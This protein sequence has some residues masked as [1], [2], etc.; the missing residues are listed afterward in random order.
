ML[1]RHFK[2]SDPPWWGLNLSKL[3]NGGLGLSCMLLNGQSSISCQS[4]S[5]QYLAPRLPPEPS[6]NTALNERSVTRPT[7]TAF[8]P[9]LPPTSPKSK[10]S[11]G[12]TDAKTELRRQV[13]GPEEAAFAGLEPSKTASTD[14]GTLS[15]NAPIEYMTNPFVQR[16]GRRF[17]RDPTLPYPLPVDLDEIHRQ[18]LRTLMLVRIFGAPFC[19]PFFE[20]SPPRKVLE[21]ACGSGLWSSACHDYLKGHGGP[22][23][24]FTGLDIAPLAPDLNLHGLDWRFVQHDLRK[25]PLPF[26]DGEFDFIFIK[27]AGFCMAT[28]ES[29]TS[30]HSEPVR[31]L[32]KGGVLEIWDSDHVFRTLL[33]HPPIPSGVTE[34]DIEQAEES[35][36]YLISPSTAF[37]KPQNKFLQNYN[38]LVEKALEKRG[39]TVAPCA[40]AAWSFTSNPDLSEDLGSRRVAIP[41]GEVRWEREGIGGGSGHLQQNRGGPPGKTKE[42]KL[43]GKPKILTADQLALRRT[44]LTTSIQFIESLEVMLKEESGKRQPEWDQ[45]WAAMTSDLLEQN[46][47]I[48]GECLE[49]G[50]WW[51]RKK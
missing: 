50:A 30:S 9:N 28:D 2:H 4:N 44:A 20:D 10:S 33:P 7:D 35:G 34:D 21:I 40:L 29:G 11:T 51:G 32:K 48:N 43:N 45:W 19:S 12:Y 36:T 47:T 1:I 37:A 26:E 8:Q 13:T 22:K 31:L 3:V 5:R 27:D 18:T 39:F 42:R 49:V 6:P 15:Q 38:T 23:T 46:G 17:L 16:H 24:S 41:F 25:M 14:P